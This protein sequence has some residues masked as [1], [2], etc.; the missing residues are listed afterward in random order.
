MK[1]KNGHAADHTAA[2]ASSAQADMGDRDFEKYASIPDVFIA[3][4][5]RS[6]G[7]DGLSEGITAGARKAP[8]TPSSAI[9]LPNGRAARKARALT[10]A[11]RQNAAAFGM[12]P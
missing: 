10:Q 1:N 2:H 8:A 6:S 5:V 11:I 12:S 9:P 3:R 4:Y 7:E